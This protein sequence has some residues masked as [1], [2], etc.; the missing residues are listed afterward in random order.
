MAKFRVYAGL[1]G[2]FGG[3][4]FKGI[5]EAE[6]ENEANGIAHELA[7]DEYQSYEGLHGLRDYEDIREDHPDVDD[8]DVIYDYYM[9]EMEEWLDYWV[10]EIT[11]EDKG[12]NEQ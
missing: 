4:E 2:G 8:E 3:A 6:T 5:Y 10:E 1:G 9:E 12:E 7:V 11:D